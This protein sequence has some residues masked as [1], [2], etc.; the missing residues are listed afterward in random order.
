MKRRTSLCAAIVAFLLLQVL[1]SWSLTVLIVKKS[2]RADF[3]N[4]DIESPTRFDRVYCDYGI[5][6]ALA[7]NGYTYETVERMPSELEQ[8]DVIFL[9]LGFAYLD[10]G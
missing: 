2:E 5:G 6:M 3:N 1:P 8:Y 7:E 10:F 4:P 9:I